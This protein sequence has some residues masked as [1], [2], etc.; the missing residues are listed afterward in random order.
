MVECC[1][2]YLSSREK[3][4]DREKVNR[5]SILERQS[6]YVSNDLQIER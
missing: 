1:V 6:L 2:A 3:D 5:R 4:S